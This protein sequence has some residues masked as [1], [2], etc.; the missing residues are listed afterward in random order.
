MRPL[1]RSVTEESVILSRAPASGQ[2]AKLMST[3]A[4][5]SHSRERRKPC[6]DET[7][8]TPVERGNLPS[9][10]V[11]N[12]DRK[13]QN[14]VTDSSA[15]CW[16]FRQVPG[17]YPSFDFEVR[18]VSGAGDSPVSTAVELGGG[19]VPGVSS[20]ASVRPTEAGLIKSIDATTVHIRDSRR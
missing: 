18:A 13:C 10:G 11:E 1:S 2:T 14:V 5:T 19:S 17:Q 12:S 15:I 7:A 16:H 8:R 6:G 9:L 3:A 4:T 20:T